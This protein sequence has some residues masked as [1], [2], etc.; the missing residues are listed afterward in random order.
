MDA[1]MTVDQLAP[2]VT[3]HSCNSEQDQQSNTRE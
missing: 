1:Q 3:D 2:T